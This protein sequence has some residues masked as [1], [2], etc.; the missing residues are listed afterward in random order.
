MAEE[1]VIPIALSQRIERS[2]TAR[3]RLVAVAA[4]HFADHGLQGASQRA[5]QRE[6]G[7]NNSTANYYFGSKEALYRAVLEAALTPIQEARATT[8]DRLTSHSSSENLL[9]RLLT[10]YIAPHLRAATSELGYSYA[11]IVAGLHL[12]IPDAAVEILEERVTPVRERYVDALSKLF[13]DAS[14]NRIYEVLRL[15]VALMA[16]TPVRHGSTHLSS[17]E[18]ERLVT[19]M[20]TVSAIIFKTLCRSDVSSK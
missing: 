4:R 12:A 1:N 17:D 9:Q 10:A 7:V 3:D 20:A 15:T 11:R 18:A 2:P 14:R 19:E 13:P 16:M 6:V 5:I 8:L